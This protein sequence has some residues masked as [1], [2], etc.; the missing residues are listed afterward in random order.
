M[1]SGCKSWTGLDESLKVCRAKGL[2]VI[3]HNDSVLKPD[4]PYQLEITN[5]EGWNENGHMLIGYKGPRYRFYGT[6]TYRDLY[7]ELVTPTQFPDPDLNPSFEDF[8]RLALAV[9]GY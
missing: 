5:T 4:K 8:A 3:K 2:P 6:V 1:S 9:K 7:G